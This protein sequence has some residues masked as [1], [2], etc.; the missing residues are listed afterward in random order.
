VTRQSQQ[1]INLILKKTQA[2]F[3]IVIYKVNG[4]MEQ[5]NFRGT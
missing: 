2:K 4:Q 3:K 1:G 5:I